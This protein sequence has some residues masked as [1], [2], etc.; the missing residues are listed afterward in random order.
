MSLSSIVNVSITNTSVQVTQAGFG[1]PMIF[2]FHSNF[3]ERIRFYTGTAG[4]VTDGFAA[5]SPEYKAA[6]AAF[7]QNPRPV[8]IAVGRRTSSAIWEVDLTPTVTTAG[9]V[10]SLTVGSETFTY[11]VQPAD[12]VALIIDGI[13]LDMGGHTGAWTPTDNTTYLAVK[14]NATG[15]LFDLV[16]D[17]DMIL[18]NDETPQTAASGVATDLDAIAVA[19]TSWYGI[20]STTHSHFDIVDVAAWAETN[21]KFYVASTLDGDV[22]AG[23]AGNIALTLQTSAYDKTATMYHPL[24]HSFPEA[25]W[26]GKMFPTDPGSA[27][28]AYKTLAGIAAV[29]LTSTETTNLEAAN[30]NYYQTIGGV[31]I[32]RTGQVASGEWCDIIRGLDWLESRIQTDVFALLASLPKIPYTDA[33]VAMVVGT[34]EARLLDAVGNGLLAPLDAGA[35]PPEGA[36]GPVVANVLAASKT[37]RLLPDVTFN[38][39]LAGAIHKTTIVGTVSV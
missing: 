28:W 15:V 30:C 34:I 19:S 2:S 16:H 37:A 17:P 13:V 6:S 14:A 11:T 18:A 33:G 23:T 36:F 5:S 35:A 25:G 31:N 26:M 10:Y 9:E 12:T 8:Q 7:A 20:I 39:T 4:M 3:V 21:K 1:V 27:T 32:T 24:V 22:A 38:A 29:E